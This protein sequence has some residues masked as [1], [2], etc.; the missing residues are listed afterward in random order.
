MEANKSILSLTSMAVMLCVVYSST[1]LAYASETNNPMTTVEQSQIGENRS[2][3]K[4]MLSSDDKVHALTIKAIRSSMMGDYESTIRY[5]RAAL[6]ET[7]HDEGIQLALQ[8]VLFQRDKKLGFIKPNP[9]VDVLLDALEYGQGSWEASIGYLRGLL[10]AEKDPAMSQAISDALNEIIPIARSDQEEQLRKELS[11][12]F[13]GPEGALIMQTLRQGFR[14]IEKGDYENAI[15]NFNDALQM[16]PKDPMIHDM[17]RYAKEL[18]QTQQDLFNKWTHQQKADMEKF[19]NEALIKEG[20]TKTVLA[21][22]QNVLRLSEELKDSEAA[23]ISQKAISIA[24]STLNKVQALLVRLDARLKALERLRAAE[25]D[26]RIGMPSVIKGNVDRMTGIGLIRFD[27]K[28]PLS[29]GDEIRTGPDGFAELMFADGSTVQI[30]PDSAFATKGISARRSIYRLL[31]GRLHAEMECLT[32]ERSACRRIR[33]GTG[34]MVIGVRG[35]E[36]D[37]NVFPDG[38]AIVSVISGN[39]ELKRSDRGDAVEV[40]AGENLM[41]T[42]RGDLKSPIPLDLRS[43]KRWWED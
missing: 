16:N 34:L 33:I 40:K 4:E 5:Y 17:L 43:M 12:L 20:E 14:A 6:K 21:Q 22:S 1:F 35:T 2:V 27:G 30:G 19:K 15:R 32:K 26:A 8:Y 36:L 24:K 23:E 18:Q 38:T 29:P 37:I 42:E 31:K 7:P 28:T 41:I 25:A 11:E 9:K 10:T 3:K 13:L 39:V